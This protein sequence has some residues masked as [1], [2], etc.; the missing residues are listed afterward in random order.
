MTSA[1]VSSLGIIT[2]CIGTAVVNISCA[3]VYVYKNR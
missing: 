2:V 3:F 1:V